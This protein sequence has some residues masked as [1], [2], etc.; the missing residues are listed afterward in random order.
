MIWEKPVTEEQEQ[1][2][3]DLIIRLNKQ[4]QDEA[5]QI[6]NWE[7]DDYYER[8]LKKYDVE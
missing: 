1:N 5:G 4:K 6:S 7:I 3:K 2:I 8:N